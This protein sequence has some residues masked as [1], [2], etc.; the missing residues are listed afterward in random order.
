MKKLLWASALLFT[1]LHCR[2]R[3]KAT[4]ELNIEESELKTLSQGKA[5]PKSINESNTPPDSTEKPVDGDLVANPKATSPSVNETK[6]QQPNSALNGLVHLRSEKAKAKNPSILLGH[7]DSFSL[8]SGL[9]F[10]NPAKLLVPNELAGKRQTIQVVE[11]DGQN[12][13]FEYVNTQE[14]DLF[15][16]FSGTTTNHDLPVL[17]D[18][19]SPSE[20]RAGEP[21][22]LY[23]KP[24]DQKELAVIHSSVVFTDVKNPLNKN[25]KRFAIDTTL[26][27]VMS[28]GLVLDKNKNVLGL[29]DKQDKNLCLVIPLSQELASKLTKIENQEAKPWIGLEL[30][31]LTTHPEAKPQEFALDYGAL[32]KAVSPGSPAESSGLVAGDILLSI[33]QQN[34][35]NES[36]KQDF[37]SM[38][39]GTPMQLVLWRN[40]DQKH[41]QLT[42]T[43]TP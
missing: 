28:G 40:G 3:I 31:E 25:E 38:H 14:E 8:G 36:L 13:L 29:V 18:I 32:I 24:T 5:P 4:E 27:D 2:T 37:E 39:I 22:T 23:S 15:S 19:V 30:L 6:A 21:V 9:L 34:V 42:P 17:D 12:S 10:G 1:T 20:L 43:A 7:G 33:N 11:Q 26:C 41:I 16:L 35:T